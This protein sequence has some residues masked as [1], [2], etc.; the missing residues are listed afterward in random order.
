M[1]RTVTVYRLELT[2]FDE[3]SQQ[4]S[5]DVSCSKG[6]YIRTIIQDIGDRLS[7]GGTMTNLVRTEACGFTLENCLTLEQA[8]EKT[9]AGTLIEEL[10]PVD[11]VFRD[12]P[13][14]R[15]NGIQAE[16]FRHGV[17]LDLNRIQ[18]L[19]SPGLHRAYGPKGRFLGL[20][21]LD[22]EKMEL[23]IEKLFDI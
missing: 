6:T 8:Q 3:I 20:A 14:L 19:D 10:L 7:V 13:L 21:S 18:Y 1:P 16:K 15:L 4:G 9:Q 5:L 23:T 12:Y 17:K 2:D 22:K 11:R